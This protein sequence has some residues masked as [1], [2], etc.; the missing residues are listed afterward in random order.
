MEKENQLPTFFFSIKFLV[1]SAHT[2][3]NHTSALKRESFNPSYDDGGARK[4]SEW[5][6]YL[7]R[8]PVRSSDTSTSI[9]RE[10]DMDTLLLLAHLILY[11]RVGIRAPQQHL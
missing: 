6:W 2:E 9:Y 7:R 5:L 8:I 3:F 4:M 1:A 10:R 11:V